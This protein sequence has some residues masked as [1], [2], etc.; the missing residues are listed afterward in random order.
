MRDK[1]NSK[2]LIVDDDI[3]LRELL[4]EAVKDWGYDVSIAV[5]GETAITLMGSEKFNTVICDLKMPGMGGL[6]FLKKIKAHYREVHVVIITGYA[7]IETAVKAIDAGAFDYLTKPF[8]LEELKAVLLKT[9]RK[10]V[11]P[12]RD[13]HLLDKLNKT[14]G[15]LDVMRAI[16]SKRAE[17]SG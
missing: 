13:A 10:T 17:D 2:V 8:R 14:Y 7:T 4:E 5:S 15:E 6:K 1:K 11:A 9:S 3:S 12:D 16:Q